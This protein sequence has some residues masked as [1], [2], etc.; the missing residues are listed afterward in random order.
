MTSR[1]PDMGEAKGADPMDIVIG[2]ATDSGHM[3]IAPTTAEEA[4]KAIATKWWNK[5]N[6]IYYTNEARQVIGGKS[7]EQV[8]VFTRI[9]DPTMVGEAR[10]DK[11]PHR[12]AQVRT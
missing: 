11:G 7:V 10:P 6:S 1:K 12:A 8:V 5:I 4:T 9:G 3:T 2:N